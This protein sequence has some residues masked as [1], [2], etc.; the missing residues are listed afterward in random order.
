ME[1]MMKLLQ[2]A[3]A[4]AT[5]GLG[6][7][8]AAERKSPAAVTNSVSYADLDLRSAAD[9]QRLKRRIRLAVHRLCL[10]DGRASPLM[11]I[12]DPDCFRNAM[13]ATRRQMD[14]AIARAAEGT[15]IAS[16]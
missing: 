13:T 9:Q 7:G 16:R 15:S 8:G 3:V 4:L 12:P 6:T 5:I 2:I 10:A 11:A 14:R 1:G